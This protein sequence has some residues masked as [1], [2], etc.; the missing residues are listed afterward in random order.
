MIFLFAIIYL[1]SVTLILLSF[2]EAL[3]LARRSYD[4]TAST[5]PSSGRITG[6]ARLVRRSLGFLWDR[7]I[8]SP[9][10]QLPF[11]LSTQAID[12]VKKLW[13]LSVSHN[14]AQLVVSFFHLRTL[15]VQNKVWIF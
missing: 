4:P 3:D 8:R 7:I 9:A 13:T 5:N 1:V 6:T 2:L 12:R 11:W 14:G 15:F 10:V